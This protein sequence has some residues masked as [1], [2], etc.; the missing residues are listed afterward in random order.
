M[1]RPESRSQAYKQLSVNIANN[2]KGLVVPV[3]P[4]V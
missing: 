1:N 3:Q 2:V 4:H